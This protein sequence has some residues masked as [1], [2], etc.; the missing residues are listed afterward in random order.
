M[1]Y[2]A[3]GS[4]QRPHDPSQL[5]PLSVPN[6]QMCAPRP[7]T[8][9]VRGVFPL[10]LHATPCL[11]GHLH[12][13]PNSIH[14]GCRSRHAW[15]PLRLVARPLRLHAGSKDDLGVVRTQPEPGMEGSGEAAVRVGPSAGMTGVAAMPKGEAG[16]AGRGWDAWRGRQ[17]QG[18][19]HG[20]EEPS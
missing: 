7:K 19:C 15:L 4:A 2:G 14:S 8:R 5:P 18:H 1:G 10:A 20:Q 6:L 3:R 11:A 12:A 17:R 13:H 16:W 9:Q